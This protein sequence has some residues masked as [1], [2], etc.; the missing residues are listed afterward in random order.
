[1]KVTENNGKLYI[2]SDDGSLWADNILVGI[3]YRDENDSRVVETS[4]DWSLT[5]TENG[6]VASTGDY[7][8]YFEYCENGLTGYTEFTNNGKEIN[9]ASDY[10][11]LSFIHTNTLD[12]MLGSDVWTSN[13][14]R[15]N[16]MQSSV[17]T[18]RL[19][20]GQK[21]WI[22][23]FAACRDAAGKEFIFGFIGFSN[24][25][26]NVDVFGD[27]ALSF[28]QAPEFHNVKH[29]EKIISD[30]FYI[31]ECDDIKTALPVY[32]EKIA[33]EM[34]AFRGL[35]RPEKFTVPAGYCT[36]YYHYNKISG[37]KVLEALEGIK[38]NADRIPLK[39]FQI[40]DGWY[41]YWGN[42]NANEKFPE[43]MKFYADKIKEAG[44][45]PGLWFAPFGASTKSEIYKN[46]PEFF[47]RD[48]EPKE[49]TDGR[50]LGDWGYYNLD[51][52]VPE[53]C[54]YIGNV[55]RRF[56]HEWGFRYLKLDI[57]TGEIGPYKHS[58]PDF[59]ACR[60]YMK[61]LQV[62]REAAAEGT[63]ILGCTAPFGS[64][65]G[66]VD[67]MRVSS[68]V[69]GGW[70]DLTHVFHQVFKRYYYHNTLFANDADCLIIRKA[71][72]EDGDCMC[73]CTR[74]DEENKSFISAM[75]ASGGNLMLSDKLDLLSEE[76]LKRLSYLFPQNTVAGIPLDIMEAHTPGILDMGQRE[77]IRTV[78]FI[79]WGVA[80]RNYSAEV[81]VKHAFDFWGQKYE[82]ITQGTYTVKL[83]PH[84]CRVMFFVD[85]ETP[86]IIGTD[87]EIIPT[88]KQTF[89]NNILTVH[90]NKKGEK[91]TVFAD[92]VK[93]D[94]CTVEKIGDKLFTVAS[95][96]GRSDG[97]LLC[98]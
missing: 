2:L 70:S 46:H 81:G 40:D 42:W 98:G 28:H 92:S 8:V 15:A 33:D 80:E 1:M 7:K 57:I 56:T 10:I 58:D 84:E 59:N 49:G 45:I 44:L 9:R 96:N 64:A 89:E 82:G 68:D 52:S 95:E 41:D 37:K 35:A 43:G 69:C 38:K 90:F 5:E 30:K 17:K 86:A 19:V 74:T 94:D 21:C 13:G 4:A 31:A 72:N 61:G 25:F 85:T 6:C 60:N 71:E 87:S 78:I 76:Q 39:Y 29:G 26:N 54:E 53:V 73:H 93:S 16:E 65:V 48:W 18:T 51:F 67:G 88:V 27:G 79:N 63:F 83:R 55:V 14:N 36:W 3:E 75:A 32:A 24:Y 34:F 97:T 20:Y 50:H 77:K 91:Y 62:I 22:A 12:C 66:L 11:P 23:D 47:I